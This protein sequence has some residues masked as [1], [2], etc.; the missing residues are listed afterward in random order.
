MSIQKWHAGKLIILWAWGVGGAIIALSDFMTRPVESATLL[1]LVEIVIV[2]TTLLLLSALTW[3]WLS[4]K[5]SSCA[6]S[7]EAHTD[8]DAEQKQGGDR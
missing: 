7:E 6:V 2:I 1:H 4:G 3:H 5:E 8:E